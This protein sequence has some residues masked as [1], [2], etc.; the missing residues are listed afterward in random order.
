MGATFTARLASVATRCGFALGCFAVRA[1]P[2]HWLFRLADGLA[3][4]GYLLFKGFR[5]RS[6]ENIQAAFHEQLSA[7]AVENIARRSLRN[8]FRDCVE[9]GVVLESSDQEIRDQVPIIGKEYLDCL[10][11]TS[12][13]P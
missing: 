7:T 9:I 4:L 11:Y 13:S 2:R 10:L 12:P 6:T 8:F 5:A 1:F 3:S